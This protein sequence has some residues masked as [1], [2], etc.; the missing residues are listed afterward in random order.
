MKN[1]AWKKEHIVIMHSEYDD[2]WQVKTVPCT[3]LQAI[4]FIRSKHW[5]AGLNAGHVQIV[6]V[7]Q[8]NNLKVA[9]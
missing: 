3:F 9:A 4:R 1:P 2:T 8:L 7:D 6:T 5:L